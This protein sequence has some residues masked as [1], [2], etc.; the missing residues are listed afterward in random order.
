MLIASIAAAAKVA[1]MEND[2]AAPPFRRWMPFPGAGVRQERPLPI[3]GCRGGGVRDKRDPEGLLMGMRHRKP[4]AGTQAAD[5]LAM[6]WVLIQEA[7]QHWHG[8][9]PGT[10]R[11]GP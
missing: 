5:K 10:Q 11:N 3:L 8:R 9:L 2:N 1:V 7:D 6:A 4:R